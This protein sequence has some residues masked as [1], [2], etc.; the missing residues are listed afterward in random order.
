MWMSVVTTRMTFLDPRAI[1]PAMD[2]ISDGWQLGRQVGNLQFTRWEERLEEPLA[3]LRR[4]HGLDP[5]GRA[6]L[7]V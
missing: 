6:P 5:A 3:Q 4:E 1:R 7:A 2:A